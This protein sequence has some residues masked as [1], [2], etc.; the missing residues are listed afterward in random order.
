MR[1]LIKLGFDEARLVWMEA[2]R[3][4]ARD[5]KSVTGELV[6][7][8]VSQ[9]EKSR[10]GGASRTRHSTLSRVESSAYPPTPITSS[11][12]VSLDQSASQCSSLHANLDATQLS[13]DFEQLTA[14]VK[15]LPAGDKEQ[16]LLRVCDEMNRN[17]QVLVNGS[18]RTALF[19]T[20]KDLYMYIHSQQVNQLM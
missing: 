9:L 20:L 7:E 2:Q 5:G 14:K 16:L 17:F 6:S 8:I 10:S 11:P 1:P 18:T 12:A 3:I 13:A 19:A 15:V 4:G